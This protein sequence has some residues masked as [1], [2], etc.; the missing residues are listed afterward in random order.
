MLGALIGDLAAWTYEHDNAT[1]WERLIPENGKGADLSVYG[2]AVLRAATCNLLDCPSIDVSPIGSLEVDPQKYYGQWLMWQLI[3]AWSEGKPAEMPGRAPYDNL[4]E[5]TAILVLPILKSLLAGASKGEAYHKASEFKRLSRN[6]KWCEPGE[7]FGYFTYVFRAWDA[8][9]HGYDFVSTVQ[10]AA[11]WPEG[12]HLTCVL[13]AMFAD[14]MYGCQ[15]GLKKTKHQGEDSIFPLDVSGE[16]LGYSDILTEKMR[17]ASMTRRAFYS[18][19]CAPTNVRNHY[20]AECYNPVRCHFSAEEVRKILLAGPTSW[21]NRY[22]L[23]L[24][25]GW[26]YCYRSCFLLARFKLREFSAN[27]YYI[28]IMQTSGEK[29]IPMS[30]WA[31]FYALTET[32]LVRIDK[33]AYNFIE[34]LGHGIFFHGE[35]E[36]RGL[37]KEELSYRNMEVGYY[38]GRYP[39]DKQRAIWERDAKTICLKDERLVKY[40]KS[41]KIPLAVKGMLAFTV[42]DYLYHVAYA[43]P[44]YDF[45]EIVGEHFGVK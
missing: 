5:D 1:F 2:H 37:S 19:N 9:Y 18:K 26:I 12:R 17:R 40:M 41:D 23:Y 16:N 6:H 22:G 33:Q 10:R 39:D 36:P 8:F 35:V 45:A 25:D 30:L 24:D 11:R 14:A 7:H 28:E 34:G 21:D 38:C 3:G 42:Q 43:D 29:D 31:V 44:V 4:I 32:C 13:A 27:E 15:L 20:W